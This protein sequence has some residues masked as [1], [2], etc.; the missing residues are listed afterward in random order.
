[1]V[2]N[3]HFDLVTCFMALQDIQNFTKAIAEVARV[4]KQQGR[5]VF[6]IPHPCFEVIRFTN[7]EGKIS[8]RERY[9]DTIKYTINWNM[10]RLTTHFTTTTFHRTL[11]DYFDA[12][13]RSNLLVKRLVEPRP[14]Q[15][16]LKQYPELQGV[17]AIPQSV[18]IE[19][20]KK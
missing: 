12:F 15:T 6:S 14:K 3:N 19:S 20:V 13:Y 18:I 10:K 11:T 9:F 8:A 1:M 2:P 7:H 16:D 17:Q 5:F 4:L